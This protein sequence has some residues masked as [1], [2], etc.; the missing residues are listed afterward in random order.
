MS[1]LHG[2]EYW[3]ARELMPCLGYLKWDNFVG[4]IKRVSGIIKHKHLEGNIIKTSR[5]VSIGS[6]A[7]RHITDY[8]I[9][10]DARVLLKELCSSR[11]LTN[12]F[13]IRNETVVLQLVEK[14]CQKKEVD[15]QFQY[16][17]KNFVF[18]ARVGDHILM[19]F[20][21]PHHSGIRQKEVDEVKDA[22]AE[23]NGF[24]LYRVDLEMDIVDIIIYLEAELW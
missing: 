24:S 16:Q 22:V 14:Y 21:E 18:D 7:S 20:D 17:F 6:G 5:K 2:V 1:D 4:V 19:E 15:F 8:L 12:V 23:A 9:D 11:K 3:S 13:S 10:E